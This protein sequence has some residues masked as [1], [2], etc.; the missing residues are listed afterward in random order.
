M[1][2]ENVSPLDV[3]RALKNMTIT[4]IKQHIAQVFKIVAF[5]VWNTA[6]PQKPTS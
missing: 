5:L 3:F 6:L 2:D 4:Q 1:N